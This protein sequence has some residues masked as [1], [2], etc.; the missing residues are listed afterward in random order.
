MDPFGR[1]DHEWPE[2]LSV[3]AH[4]GLPDRVKCYDVYAPDPLAVAIT[5]HLCALSLEHP[6]GQK[7]RVGPLWWKRIRENAGFISVQA[8]E[9][10]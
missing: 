4:L 3:H 1:T 10:D 5:A 2:T 6:P 9:L 8:E 7:I